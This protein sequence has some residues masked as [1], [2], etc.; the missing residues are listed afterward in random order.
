MS[1]ARSWTIAGYALLACVPALAIGCGS[2]RTQSS[3]PVPWVDRTVARYEIP[4]PKLIP[5]SVSAPL[6]R[7]S[8]LRVRQG[9]GGAAAGTQYERLVLTNVGARTCLLRGYPTITGVNEG[10]RSPLRVRREGVVFFQ[11]VPTDVRPGGHSFLELATSD[12]C[13]GGRNKPTVYRQLEIAVRG[14]GTVRAPAHVEIAD[15]C[16]LYVS[17]FGLPARYTP[18]APQP[19]TAGT[20]WATLHLPPT[21]QAG[22]V[23]AY[24]IT[25]SN[26]TGTAVKVKPC[27]G[28]NEGIYEV[29]FHVRRWLA[30][31]CST[32]QVIGS[33]QAVRFAMELSVPARM[34]AGRAKFA[35]SLDTPYGPFAGG[36]ITVRQGR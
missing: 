31:N 26:R 28:Y 33:H 11:L 14:V 32:V 4:P 20:L 36:V 30:L 29:G 35:W 7:A 34:P 12:A 2:A 19:G 27:P 17:Y 9:R 21:V 10:T 15:V 1:R 8:Q 22:H 13:N 5:Y 3:G 25:L 23:L 18:V 6:C 16:G 24:T